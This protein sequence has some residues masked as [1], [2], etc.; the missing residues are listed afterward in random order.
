MAGNYEM[1]LNYDNDRQTFMFPMLPE[2]LKVTYKGKVTSIVIDKLGEIFHKG[3]RDAAVI[4]FSAVF[5]NNYGSYCACTPSNF[6]DP[7]ECVEWI[8]Q[9]MEAD[10]PAHFKLVGSPLDIDGYFLI[11]SFVPD[12]T[13]GDVGSINYTIEMKEYRTADVSK[14]KVGKKGKKKSK[15]T[16]SGKKRVNNKAKTK[17]Y[18]IKTGDT[19]WDIS[20]K[21]YGSGSSYTKIY[22]ANKTVLDKAAKNHGFRGC[23]GGNRIW[24]GTKITIP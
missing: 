12:E 17:N 16:S 8:V 20:I 9:L 7:D 22:N 13:G 10:N 4:S 14:V 11:T 6:K 19:L 1:W 2:K 5:P 15:K 3:P 23:N 21:Y 18:T 24:P